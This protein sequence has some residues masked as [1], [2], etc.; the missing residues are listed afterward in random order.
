MTIVRNGCQLAPDAWLLP[1]PKS[2][3]HHDARKDFFFLLT[4][5]YLVVYYKAFPHLLAEHSCHAH[6]ATLQGW[7]NL[8]HINMHYALA[9]LPATHIPTVPLHTQTRPPTHTNMP[10]HTHT[11]THTHKHT[12]TQTELVPFAAFG[13]YFSDCFHKARIC[14]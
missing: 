13:S 14:T 9:L 8:A 5:R 12:H 3:M 7:Y 10:T 2:R 1:P 11:H 4:L 6:S